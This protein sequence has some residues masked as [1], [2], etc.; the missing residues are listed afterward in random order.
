MYGLVHT[1]VRDMVLQNHGPATWEQIRSDAGVGDEDFLAMKSYDDSIILNLVTAASETL[2]IS[3]EECLNAFGQFW[4]LDT[5]AK[6]YS[7]MIDGFGSDMWALL[8][9][10][11]HMHDRMSSTFH[12][13]DPPS[14]F[15]KNHEDGS[16]LLHYRSSRQGL[17]PFVIGLLNGLAIHF[18]TTI[19]IA[20]DEETLSTNGQ[21]TVFRLTERNN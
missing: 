15:L 2:Q 18:K 17:T 5:A 4:V 11:D 10:L 7:E 19:D 3:P 9:N 13:Y 14:F 6:H 20:I 12:G 21:H 8:E 1:S 16:R